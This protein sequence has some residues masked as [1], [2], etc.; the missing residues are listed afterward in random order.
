MTLPQGFSSTFRLDLVTG[1]IKGPRD[2]MECS[3]SY[4]RDQPSTIC[5]WV[6][7]AAKWLEGNSIHASSGVEPQEE[8]ARR[9]ISSSRCQQ[10]RMGCVSS[11]NSV[12]QKRLVDNGNHVILAAEPITPSVFDTSFQPLSVLISSMFGVIQ[13]FKPNPS[14]SFELDTPFCFKLRFISLL[15]PHTSVASLGSR[16]TGILNL[17]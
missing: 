6:A 9:A 17:L 8:V 14:G 1:K 2:E 5:H 4:D 10:C 7:A 16:W 12:V 15:A 3:F 11:L 13:T